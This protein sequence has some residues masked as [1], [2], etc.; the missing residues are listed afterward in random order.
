MTIYGRKI[1]D[2]DMSNIASFMN[3]EI[4][5]KLHSE[6]APCK[7]EEFI[8]EYLKI[9]HTFLFTLEKNFDFEDEENKRYEDIDRD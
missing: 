9:D 1:T 3:D 7:P 8:R 6:L 4:R 5:E 2:A